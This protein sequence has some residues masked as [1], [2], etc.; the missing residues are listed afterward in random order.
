MALNVRRIAVLGFGEAGGILGEELVKADCEVTMYDILLDAPDAAAAMR[1]RAE[2]ARV[3]ACESTPAAVRGADLIISAVT[4]SSAAAAAAAASQALRPGQ[5][6]MDIN[7]V[8]PAAKCANAERIAASG[9]DYIEAAVM[10]PVPAQR[11]AVPMLLGGAR[12]NELA[13][14]LNSLGMKITAIS[15]QIG[16]ASAVKM[17]RSIVIKGMEA[18]TLECVMAARRLGAEKEVLAS[19]DASFPHMGWQQTLPS[20]LVGRIAEHGARRAAE[21]REVAR[22]LEDAGIEPLMA[23]ATALRQQGLVDAMQARGIE[24]SSGIAA[25]W[26]AL[27]D[28]LGRP[29][30]VT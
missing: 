21:M 3:R 15:A 18:L 5:I 27:V 2:R 26:A 29:A 1:R 4:A 23:S 19:L 28:A 16:M 17:C 20:Y 11:L 9:A 30:K 7:S 10:A 25:S 22:T 12:A 8:S 14:A 24:Y 6:F 13:V